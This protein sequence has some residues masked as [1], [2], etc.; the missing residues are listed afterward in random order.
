MSDKGKT[1]PDYTDPVLLE[2]LTELKAVFD[3]GISEYE[4]IKQLQQPPWLL[5]DGVALSEPLAMFRCHFVLFNAL[6]SL[7]EAWRQQGLGELDIHTLRIR[8]KPAT[9]FEAGITGHDGLKAYYLNWDNFTDTNGADVEALLDDFWQ[10]MAGRE[11]SASDV[12]RARL[13]LDLDTE[14]TLTTAQLKKQYRKLLQQHHPD[15]GGCTAKA[16]EISQAYRILCGQR[17]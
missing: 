17:N 11:A 16:Q 3:E 9:E 8:L 2:A 6:Y 10:R 1:L 14:E 4:L 15:K 7:S 5:F 13:T 12:A